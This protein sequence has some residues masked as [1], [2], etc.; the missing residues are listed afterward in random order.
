MNYIDWLNKIY[1]VNLDEDIERRISMDEAFNTLGIKKYV[2]YFCAPRPNP[3]YTSSNFQFAGEFGCSLSHL[4]CLINAAP[5]TEEHDHGILILEDDLIF[6]EK[7]HE[8]FNESLVSIPDDW[9]V[10]YLG[11]RPKKKL[12]KINSHLCKVDEFLQTTGY[13]VRT[14]KIKA[15]AEYFCDRLGTTF[16]NACADKILNDFILQ[17]SGTGYTLYPPIIEQQDGYSTLRFGDRK[18]KNMI[19]AEWDKFKP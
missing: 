15:L 4:K 19:R 8:K 6:D 1:C 16:P 3:D 13:V 14:S 5:N 11:G 7:F 10:L 2:K 12:M 17:D 18:Y 9:N